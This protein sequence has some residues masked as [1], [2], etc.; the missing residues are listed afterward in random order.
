MAEAAAG[1]EKINNE[2]AL[3]AV[4]TA[5]MA[6]AVDAVAS[7]AA[8][9]EGNS[10]GGGGSDDS[11]GNGDGDSGDEDSGGGGT[12]EELRWRQTAG[13]ADCTHC[14]GVR[15]QRNAA[16]DCCVGGVRRRWRVMPGA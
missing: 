6:A 8:P 16:A 13:A 10:G 11:D 5:V 14:S 12:G 2:A 9:E 3:T 15:G 1:N 4:E 7:A